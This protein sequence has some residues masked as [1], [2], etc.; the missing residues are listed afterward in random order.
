MTRAPAAAPFRRVLLA[1]S[2]EQAA[3]ELLGTLLVRTEEDGRETV[4]RIVETEAYGP[5]DPASHSFRGPTAR[6]AAMF[7]PPGTAYVYRSYGVH[8]CLNVAAE[9]EGQGAAVLLRAAVLLTNH[10]HVRPRRPTAGRDRDLLLE[11]TGEQRH[12]ISYRNRF[13]RRR[14]YTV[15]FDGML[16]SL[17]NRYESTESESARERIEGLMA[18]RPCPACD[19][20]R[21]R[22]ESLAVTVGGLNVH[23]FTQLSA[24]RAL[25]WISELELTETERAIAR[26]VVREIAERLRFLDS[27][28]MG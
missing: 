8:W 13:G 6:N 23:Q 28:R 11:G 25:E 5:D 21:L 24:H 2:V 3:R 27:V 15:R 26:L 12:T 18:L 22:P 19:G 17:Q 10:G 9:P 4:A 14:R 20:A 7:G 1:A 16:A